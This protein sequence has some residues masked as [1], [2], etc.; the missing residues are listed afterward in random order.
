MALLDLIDMLPGASR[1]HEAVSLDP[2]AAELLAELPEP[3]SEGEGEKWAPR[4]ADWNLNAQQNAQI[5]D[6][7]KSLRTVLIT[8]NSEKGSSAPPEEPHP[9]PRTELERVRA[10][11]RRRQEVADIAQF[12]FG[13][14]D[15]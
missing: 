9:V 10:R 12:G 5:I 6:L 7:L 15:I 1:Y 8:A 2:E 3:D 13:P 4:M 11:R 14:E